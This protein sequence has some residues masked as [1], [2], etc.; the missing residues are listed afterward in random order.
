M[1]IAQARRTDSIGLI[2]V[3]QNVEAA[4]E[5]EESH[6]LRIKLRLRIAISM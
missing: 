3:G 6:D 4:K 1:T 2:N 5:I